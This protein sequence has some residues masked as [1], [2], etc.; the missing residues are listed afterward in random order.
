M[1]QIKALLRSTN[2]RFTHRSVSFMITPSRIA[3]SGILS[4]IR[5]SST[6]V[7]LFEAGS[8]GEADAN[9]EPNLLELGSSMMD[10]DR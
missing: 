9:V 8:G 10:F 4:R 5:A 2:S 7:I 3:F 6:R 1:I